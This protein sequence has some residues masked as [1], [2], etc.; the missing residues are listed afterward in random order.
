MT[1]TK[2]EKEAFRKAGS[3]YKE[4]RISEAL[5][6]LEELVEK[7]PRSAVLLA[8][9]ANTYWDL[10]M[11]DKAEEY[12]EMSIKYGPSSE[13]ISLGYFHLLWERGKKEEAVSEIQRFQEYAVLSEDY[14]E[15]ATEINQKTDFKIEIGNQ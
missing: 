6:I 9:L 14:L 12:F 10:A 3:L 2:Q 8:T 13:K 7:R 4:G 1:F 5:P 11:L 15:I